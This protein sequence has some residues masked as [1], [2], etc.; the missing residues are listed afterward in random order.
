M[1]KTAQ[2]SSGEIV[3]FVS[4]NANAFAW[5]VQK[6]RIETAALTRTEFSEQA[7]LN[8][9]CAKSWKRRGLI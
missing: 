8:S 3:L 5:S 4:N 1:H 9:A 7:H 2:D 6:T